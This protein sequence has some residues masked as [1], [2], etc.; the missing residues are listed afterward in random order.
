[1]KKEIAD[2]LNE[3]EAKKSETYRCSIEDRNN[4]ISKISEETKKKIQLNEAR[5]IKSYE[6]ASRLL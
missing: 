1:M 4:Y 5:E 2:L 6:L 3:L